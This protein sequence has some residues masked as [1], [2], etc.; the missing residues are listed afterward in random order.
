M[1]SLP[2]YAGPFTVPQWYVVRSVYAK[3]ILVGYFGRYAKMTTGLWGE[4]E[5]S[6]LP[7]QSRTLSVF[8]RCQKTGT[9][10][11]K[12]TAGGLAVAIYATHF[13]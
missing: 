12:Q 4:K 13:M 8:L 1:V 3:Q 10:C 9:F 6:A 11:C 2:P 5:S 7:M